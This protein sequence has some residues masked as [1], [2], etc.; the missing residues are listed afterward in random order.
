MWLRRGSHDTIFYT[1]R[2]GDRDGGDSDGCVVD[3]VVI[4]VTIVD[5]ERI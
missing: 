4:A 2:G 1:Q 3:V 5:I